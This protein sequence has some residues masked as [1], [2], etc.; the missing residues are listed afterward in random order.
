[1]VSSMESRPFGQANDW[2]NPAIYAINKLKPHVPLKSFTCPEQAFQHFSSLTQALPS[3]RQYSL[4]GNQW[5][6][7]LFDRPEQVPIEFKDVEYDDKIDG[8]GWEEVSSIQGC[9]K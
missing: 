6:F 7:K 9:D 3:P 2:E 1:M 4:N 8:S 5:K